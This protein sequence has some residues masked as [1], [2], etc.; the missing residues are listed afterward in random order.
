MEIKTG[1]SNLPTITNKYNPM[2]KKCKYEFV[3]KPKNQPCRRFIRNNLAGKVIMNLRTLK[4]CEFKRKLGFN[5]KQQ[6]VTETTKDASEGENVETEY[7][8]RLQN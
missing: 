8:F 1:H 6:T 2:Y 7:Y 3:D 4:S 5:V